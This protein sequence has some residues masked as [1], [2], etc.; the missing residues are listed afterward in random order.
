MARADVVSTM[1][2]LAVVLLTVAVT[3]PTVAEV[4]VTFPVS[5]PQ[6]CVSLA[7]QEGVPIVIQNKYQAAKAEIKLARLKDNDQ[8]CVNVAPQ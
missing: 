5:I 7:Q 1:R 3:T 6:E 4:T 2:I 8:W